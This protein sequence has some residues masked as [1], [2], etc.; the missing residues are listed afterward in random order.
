[1]LSS[2]PWVLQGPAPALNSPTVVIPPNNPVSGAIQ[3]VAPN[4]TNANVLFVG[5]V[6]GGVWKTSNAT[7]PS[8]TW[9]PLT[10]SLPGQSISSMSLDVTDLTDQTLVVGTGRRSSLPAGTTPAGDDQ[11]GL[12]YT[13]NGGVS[14]TQFNQSILRD[15]V[16][17]GVAARGN[18]ILAGSAT[19]G[20]YRSTDR[21]ASWTLISG[22]HGL[23]TGGVFD[24]VADP[25]NSNRFYAA[26]KGRGLFRTD[27]AGATWTNVTAGITGTDLATNM[28][29]GVHNSTGANVV[30]V[31]VVDSVNKQLAGVFRSI[32]QGVSWTAM[33]V[34][35]IHP[36][37][38]G[39]L[40]FSLAAD[41][42]NPN[43]VYMGGDRI[44]ATAYT[45]NL[46]RGD[47]SLALGSQ[48]TS[49][50]D[51]GGGSTSTHNDSRYLGFDANGNLLEGDDGGIYRRSTPASSGSWGS[52][53]G[54]LAVMETHDVAWDSISHTAI[55]G[56]QANGTQQ[57]QTP[58]GTTTWAV[59]SGRDGG[60]VAVDNVSLA[61]SNQAIRYFSSENLGKAVAADAGDLQR[62][63]IDANNNVISTTPIN[64]STI[65]DFQLVTPIKVN[66]VDPLR[67]LVGGSTKLYESI[68][69]GGAFTAISGSGANGDGDP[70]VYGGISN[71]VL[72]P[73]LIYVGKGNK[74]F[75]RTAA[76][77]SVTAT[78]A[79][80]GGTS[81][82]DVTDIAVDSS[83][84]KTVFAID[85]SH[86]F[87]SRDAGVT[88]TDVTGDLTSRALDFHSLAFVHGVLDSSLVVG[89][90]S[91]VF[92]SHMSEMGTWERLGTGLPDV[93]VNDLD[94]NASDDVLVAGTLGRSVWTFTNASTELN[95]AP[96]VT[97][98]TFKLH[99]NPGATKV[100]YLD[101]N[102]QNIRDTAW[103]IN[104]FGN[105]ISLPYNTDGDASTFS[106]AEMQV[107][108][109]VWKRVSEDFRPFDVDVTTEDP[110]VEALKNTGGSDDQWGQRIVI[111]GSSA[112]WY[113]VVNPPDPASMAPPPAFVS[114][115]DSNNSFYTQVGSDKNDTPAFIFTTDLATQAGATRFDKVLA[116]V[117]SHV[118]GT[119]LGLRDMGQRQLKD[120]GP[121]P[122]FTTVAYP[123]HGTGATGWSSIMGTAFG[124]LLAGAGVDKELTQWAKGEYQFADPI[125][126]ELAQIT[127]AQ[128]GVTYRAD[129]NTAPTALA[130]DTTLSTTNQL[131]FADKGIIEQNTDTDDF[132]ITVDGLGG[133][134]KLDISPFKTSP[135]LDIFATLTD[136]DGNVLG[137]SNPVNSLA[138]G[139]QT[140]VAALPDGGWQTAPGVYTDTF[141]LQAGTYHLII[142]GIGKP[143]N[144]ANPSAPDWGYSDYGSLG[145]YSITGTLGK[146]LV[147]G[148]DF[149]APGG[150]AP[151]NW[152]L[153][154]G[155]GTSGVVTNLISEAGASVPYQLTVSTTG[156]SIDT[157]ASANPIAS[158][159]LPNHAIALNELGGY[160]SAENQ[161]TTF[162]WSN[163]EPWSYHKVYVFGHADFDAHN[164]VTITGGNL[165]GTVQTISFN[166]SIP[167]NG[168]EVN[169]GPLGNGDLNT[170]AVTVLSDG[171]GQI[172]IAVTNAPGFESAIAGLAIAPT[173]KIGPPLNGSIS[174]QKWNDNG[175][176]P[177]AGNKI[178]D[179]GES[180]LEGWIIYLD[181]NNN[182]K[183]DSITTPPTPDQTLTVA[184]SDI[185]QAI[186]DQNIIGVKSTLDFTGVGTIEDIN[187]ALDITHSYDADLHAVLISPSGT[188]VKLFTNVG[189]N[190]D[191]FHNTVLDDSALISITT[192][193]APFTGTFRPEEPLSA[194]SNEN[195]FGSWQLELIDDS[196][197]DTGVLNSWSITVKLKG[198]QGTTQYLEPVQTT[199][200]SGNYTFAALPPGLYNIREYIQPDQ[201]A[202]GWQQ[203]WAP[204][205]ITVTSGADI[206]DVDF[207]NWIPEVKPGLIQGQKFSDTNQNGVK[208]DGEA[209]LP[210]WIVYIDVNN[211]GVRDI[212]STPTVIDS[213]DVAKPILDLKTVQSHVNVGPLG[214]VF[215]VEVKLDITHSYMADLT[216]YLV[217]PAGTQV[218]LFAGVGGQYNDFHN[219]T[220]S[221]DG[222]RSISTI[223]FNDLPYTGVWKPQGSLSSFSGEDAAGIWTLVISDTVPLDEGI[224]N[225]W[226]L[227]FGSG[228]LFRTTDAD[229]NYQFDNVSAGSY[230]VREESQPGWSQVPPVDT[231]IPGATWNNSRWNVTVVATDNPNDPDGPDSHRNVRNVDFGNIAVLNLAGDF[232]RDGVVDGSDYIVWRRAL[233]SHVNS[234]SG[235][236]GDGNGIVEQADLSVWQSH[237]GQTLPGSGSGSALATA[238]AGSGAETQSLQ[239]SEPAPVAA[240]P[241]PFSAVQAPFSTQVAANVVAVATGDSA[242]SSVGS[243]QVYEVVSVNAIVEHDTIVIE[244]PSESTSSSDLGLLAWL[245]ASSVGERPQADLTS[246]TDQDFSVASDEPESVDIA[247]E[248]LEGNALASATI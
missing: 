114:N 183:L 231:S 235:A 20:L 18:V 191:N 192:E 3:V 159:D 94:Y 124:G 100:I 73:N 44:G 218:P 165:N 136:A 49:I 214:T 143:A 142:N 59:I 125:E 203:T 54:N 240:A 174:G 55:V 97:D 188:R 26:V 127:A 147:V 154:T 89:T 241:K 53:V 182:G 93:L 110:G 225:S 2:S 121:P 200:A 167:A 61:A 193:A 211:N 140:K 85:K 56:T 10:D 201:V 66:A 132:T 233:G 91:G 146:A 139:G 232:N 57:Q 31:G 236:D 244:R 117:V 216:A 19:N 129:D 43:L 206:T 228:E 213:T 115:P 153:Y 155:G 23:L 179:P 36:G 7:S 24:L 207:G 177:L 52:V 95:P 204:T 178:K 180:G 106:N 162:T 144:L 58:A 109:S 219:V 126:D 223:G 138:A 111:G 160:I 168:L 238:A 8:P 186:P 71:G 72:N 16:F 229:G 194:F 184:S 68:N 67:I 5:A 13:T 234:F 39:D 79:L 38:Q 224:L 81:V 92:V 133:I 99:S 166:Q 22:T 12:Y 246:L 64:A 189:L 195:A 1:M 149:D 187:V 130:L 47:A 158:A 40:Y 78:A 212:A 28:R 181:E 37:K 34:P 197:G 45:G 221:D 209:G 112:D 96:I 230:I 74:V 156:T 104:G 210:G 243:M 199:N 98:Q 170:Y 103:N 151:Q 239:V 198:A 123:G 113:T 227:S 35:A 46:V 202:A 90:R 4:P 69:Q 63:V 51:S 25:G 14:W 169:Q 226:S 145:S 248:L 173:Q 75:K 27:D 82:T 122:K 48:F 185:P 41:P 217:S 150:T 134:L 76:G 196:V 21:G 176:G 86:V 137:T 29:I 148:V 163:L 152:N 237:Y 171:S 65:T 161:T 118:V 242:K 88:W 190:G 101:F 215:N 128:T 9:T 50:V 80:P 157:S 77:G 164:V 208:D 222:V 17:N 108:Q 84:W 102:G 6:N 105:I 119:T 172:S 220:F 60:D 30:Y 141:F 32:N 107:I 70:L 62:Q 131:V 42:T 135:N 11:V 87:M 175:A 120:P 116:E 247:F 205:P 15:Q 83:E 245:A 33:D